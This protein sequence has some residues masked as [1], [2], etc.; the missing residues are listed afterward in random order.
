MAAGDGMVPGGI[1]ESLAVLMLNAL[2]GNINK[3]GGRLRLTGIGLRQ[4]A[5]SQNR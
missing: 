5:G 3:T 1:D 2:V 4:V